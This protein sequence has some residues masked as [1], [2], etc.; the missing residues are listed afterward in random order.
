MP[1]HTW[2]TGEL[3]TAEKLNNTGGSIVIVPITCTFN[4]GSTTNV[5]TTAVYADIV[6]AYLAGAVIIFNVVGNNTYYVQYSEFRYDTSNGFVFGLDD[7]VG[8]AC[9][10]FN[11]NGAYFNEGQIGY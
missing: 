7:M 10:G 8:G 4:N 2:E 3:I 11:E 5:Q 9:W 1:K 6:S